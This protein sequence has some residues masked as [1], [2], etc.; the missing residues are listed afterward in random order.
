MR[1]FNRCIN[2]KK[3]IPNTADEIKSIRPGFLTPVNLTKKREIS[4]VVTTIISCP[5]SKP[6]LKDNKGKTMLS[7][8]LNMDFKR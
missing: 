4:N 7:S 1:I 8:L 6:K 3:E 2:N 5:I